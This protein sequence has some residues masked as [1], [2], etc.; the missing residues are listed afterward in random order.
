MPLARY[1]S[2]VGAALLALLLVLDAYLPEL[3]AVEKTKVYPPVIRIY[4]DEKWPERIVYDTSLPTVPPVVAAPEP[5]AI[6]PEI[7]VEAPSGTK[8]RKAFAMMAPSAAQIVDGPRKMQ[9]QKRRQHRK[10][11][12]NRTAPPMITIARNQQFVWFGRNW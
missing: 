11:T 8:A 2:I 4:V 7:M 9:L 10:A 5:V 6:A 1:F 3:P 12:R